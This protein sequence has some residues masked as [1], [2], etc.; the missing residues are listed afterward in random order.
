[1]PPTTHQSPNALGIDVAHFDGTVNWGT[2]LKAGMSFGFAKATDGIGFTD[3]EF[4]ANWNMMGQVGIT[5]GAYHFFRGSQD[6]GKQAD[7][8]LSVVKL[9]KTDMPPVL[10]IEVPDGVASKT[11]IDGAKAWLDAVEKATGRVPI[12]YTGPAFWSEHMSPNFGRYPLWIA[13]YTHAPEPIVPANWNKWTFWQYA[14]GESGQV[15]IPGVAGAVDIN[16]FNG[17]HADLVKLFNL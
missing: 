6:A 2:V 11:L 5:R 8:F 9:I 7:H 12:I 1:M 3:S 14:S 17:T 16:R 4:K 15:H 13:H 10:D